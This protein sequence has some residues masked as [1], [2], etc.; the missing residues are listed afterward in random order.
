MFSELSD[1]S[2]L[3]VFSLAE[4]ASPDQVA[5]LKRA[6][7]EFMA[8]WRAHGAPVSGCFAVVEDRFI[9]VAAD[10]LGATVSGCSIDSMVKAVETAVRDLPLTL[11]DPSVIFYRAPSGEIRALPRGE[12]KALAT[13]SDFDRSTPVFNPV[14]SSVREL[15]ESGFELPFEAAWHARAFR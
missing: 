14:L 10:S 13:A 6:L 9:L 12:F 15:R 8:E 3:W 2:K 7:T 1:D 5:L 4:R 11:A